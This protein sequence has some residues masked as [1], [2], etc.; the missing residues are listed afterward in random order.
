MV[1]TGVDLIEIERVAAAIDRF[2]LRFLERIFTPAEL[3]VCANK[4]DSLAVRFAA[5][6]AV[7]KALGAGIWRTGIDWTDIEV[8]RDT[9]SGEP[10]LILHGE[11]A[12][13]SRRLNISQWSISLSHA[14]RDAIA[15]VIAV[16]E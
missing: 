15:F 14:R 5:K 2:G 3:V 6:E 1:R 7:A 10:R 8:L 16:S 11:A 13:Q 12:E 4:A 9:E